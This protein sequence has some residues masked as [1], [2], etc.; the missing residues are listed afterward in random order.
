MSG[1][2][3][4]KR[5]VNT[6]AVHQAN[7]LDRLL[8]ER[9]AIPLSYPCIAIAPPDD[10]T[11]LD[12]ALRDL[13]DRRFSWLVFTSS[14][15]VRAIANRLAELD[16]IAPDS[17]PIAVV[18]PATAVAV[19]EAFGRTP[20]FM[21]GRHDAAAL[22]AGLP[23]RPGE[24]VLAPGSN[25]ARPELARILAERGAKVTSVV[26]YRTVIG[27]GVVD[28]PGML[29]DGL[30]DALTFASPSA[31]RGL[32]LRLANEGGSA[33]SLLGLPAVCIGESTWR[34]A[35]ELGL[36]SLASP[37]QTLEG[38]VDT[39]ER[40]FAPVGSGGRRWS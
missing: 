32:F 35:E 2:L 10:C 25:I 33:L 5:I 4:G 18:G 13:V 12:R 23:V 36:A 31:V 34:T 1:P 27:S 26:A 9:G 3:H 24:A 19:Q 22:A 7:A 39:L 16:I 6:R 40:L 20:Q 21:P 38:M 15:T 11:V 28:L 30:V 17:M 8:E 14:N 29:T 37:T